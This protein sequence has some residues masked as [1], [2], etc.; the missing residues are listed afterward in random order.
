MN[1]QATSV[2]TQSFV[3][4]I[5]QRIS[6]QKHNLLRDFQKDKLKD[7]AVS[8]ILDLTVMSQHTRVSHCFIT[9]LLLCLLNRSFDRSIYAL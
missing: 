1:F 5:L 6:L 9:S 3:H 8:T 7:D 2:N 4:F